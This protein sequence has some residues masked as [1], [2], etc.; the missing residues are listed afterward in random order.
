LDFV[1]GLLLNLTNFS[2]FDSNLLIIKFYKFENI[3][4][5]N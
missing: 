5:F 3:Y 4:V 2:V 1:D